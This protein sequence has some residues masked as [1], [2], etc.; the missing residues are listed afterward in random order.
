M[1]HYKTVF[2]F[3]ITICIFSSWL[4]PYINNFNVI[5]S[6]SQFQSIFS[7]FP[8]IKSAQFG[9][10]FSSQSN[11]DITTK[12]FLFYPYLTL[13]FYGLLSWITGMKG[14]I[15]ISTIVFPTCSFYVL[16]RI[17]SRQLNKLWSLT[18]SLTCILAFSDWPFRFFLIGIIKGQPISELT[19]IQP[20]EIAHY[21]IPSFSVFIFLLIFYFSTEHKKLTFARI[22]L[23][24]CL[25]SLY[26][27][28]HAVDAIYGLSFWFIFFPIQFIRQSSKLL[29]NTLIKTFVFQVL[30]CLLFVSP[31]IIYLKTSSVHTTLENI[32]IFQSRLGE[33]FD[34]FYL[35]TYFFLPLTLTSIVFIVKKID[36]YEILTRFIHVYILL[37]VEFVLVSSSM[38]FSKGFEI[39]IVQTRIALFF[40]HFYYYAPFIYMVTR[41]PVFSYSHG[42]EAKM[43][44]KK[45]EHGMDFVFNRFDKIY[46][47]LI[48]FFL[49]IYTGTSSYWNYRHYKDKNETAVEEIMSEYNEIIN[50]LPIGSVLVSETPATNLLPL[51]D[52][53]SYY[54]TLWINRFAH[55][56]PSD[57]IIDRLL[58]YAHIFNWPKEKVVR[59]LS[60]GQLQE[61]RGAIV[62][63]SH[64]KIQDS[65][66]GYWLVYHKRKM[67]E[68]ELNNYLFSLSDR[69]KNIN[70][71]LMLS[72]FGVTHIYSSRPISM[73][74]AVNS[75]IELDKGF[76][77][78][79]DTKKGKHVL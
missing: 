53:N 17:F 19:T 43:I 3:A 36:L 9:D 52:L 49:F 73:E 31:L 30:I 38:F 42:V 29:N 1:K 75:V 25:W 79:V 54:K 48:I 65:G 41:S 44:S 18:V 67:T 4:V 69:Y 10:L 37:F 13:W 40:L 5:Y 57:E 2:L 7:W 76:L 28:V 39:D 46:L 26:S 21:P 14:I 71:E 24:T 34:L 78:H 60:P 47:P 12:D 77:Y 55:D 50:L 20:L 70:I 56:L 23:F 51:I 58:L 74:I 61:R 64:Q 11:L 45:I 59:F 8:L 63:L 68:T 15:I 62:D 16:N 66:V 6:S 22:T 32:G 72:D 27:Q 35:L 33:R